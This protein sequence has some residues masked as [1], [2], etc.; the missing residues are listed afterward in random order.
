MPKISFNVPHG[1]SAADALARMHD[2]LPKIKEHY[3][4]QVKDMEESFDG[5]TLNFSFKTMGF[6]FKGAI[7]AADQK[8]TVDMELPFAALMIKGR[9][10]QEITA[11]LARLLR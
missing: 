1:L 6:V 4:D 8:V 10:E 11:G 3:K 2:F 7:T 9:I 5:Q